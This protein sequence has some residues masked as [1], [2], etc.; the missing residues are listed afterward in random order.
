MELEQLQS[1][2][3][4]Y[5]DVQ[6]AIAAE[7]TSPKVSDFL[8][9]YN[10]NEHKIFSTTERPDKIVVTDESTSSVKVARLGVPM[11]KRIVQMA[12]TFL[13]GRPIKLHSVPADQSQT[14]LLAAMTRTWDDNKLDYDT[15]ELARIL[16]SETEVAE[17]WYAEDAE[18][19]YWGQ[20]AMQTAKVRL[21]MKIVA[22]SL[23]DKLYP[24]FNAAG[25][26]IAF[27]RGFTKTV[28][29][30]KIDC[31]DLYTEAETIIGEKGDAGWVTTPSKNMLNKIPVIYYRRPDT[32]WNDIQSL[33]ERFESLLSNSADNNDYYGNPMIKV[34]GQVKGFAK[35]GEQGKIIEIDG[36]GDA[37]YMTHNGANESVQ[38][39]FKMLRS[40]ILDMTDTPD[41]SFENMRGLGAFSAIA[42]KM[43]FLGAHMKAS[44]NE[45]IFGKGIQRRLNLIK[46]A[47][48]MINTSFES[49]V[50]LLNVKPVF[51]YFIPEDVEAKVNTLINAV[52]VGKGIMSQETAVRMNPLITDADAEISRLE[53]ERNQELPANLL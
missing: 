30:K 12:V 9:Q 31:Y 18:E 17:I 26:M 5:E 34:K 13:C 39:E 7:V 33:I 28:Q 8:K 46:A 41:I 43:M 27:G 48:G 35:K 36:D 42:L 22:N 45:Q 25:D 53:E 37:E 40:L 20:G 4:N 51:E 11:Q 29:G 15:Q 1:L 32:E 6:K 44:S 14:D 47:M 49:I 50:P 24:V 19:G 52:G 2:L 21:R 38:S 16:F 3:T 10:V 23:G